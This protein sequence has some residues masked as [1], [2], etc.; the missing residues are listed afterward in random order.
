MSTVSTVHLGNKCTQ[1]WPTTQRDLELEHEWSQPSQKAGVH[2]Q[3][4]EIAL[5]F[6]EMGRDMAEMRA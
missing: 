6:P 5:D 3:C 2:A 1:K 4:K